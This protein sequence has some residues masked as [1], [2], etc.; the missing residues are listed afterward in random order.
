MFTGNPRIFRTRAEKIGVDTAVHILL[1]CS[2]SMGNA[3]MELAGKA[4][5]AVTSAL[6]AIPGVNVAVTAF[7]GNPLWDNSGRRVWNTVAPILKHGERMHGEF[8]LTP[9]G[10]TPLGEALWW[11]MQQMQPLNEPRKIIL[12]IT[13]GHP[14]S[15][16]LAQNAILT[17][18][19][20]GY[21]VYGIGIGDRTGIHDL[22]PASSMT[23][24]TL[25]ELASAMFTILSKTLLNIH[26]EPKLIANQI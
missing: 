24:L 10:D 23:I 26:Q 16:A 1:D 13:D 14:D 17:A 11:A 20:V 9:Y 8:S 4:C 2:G 6:H 22:L 15:R 5:F 18:K 7:P 19:A 25:P 3:S 12:A 21:E